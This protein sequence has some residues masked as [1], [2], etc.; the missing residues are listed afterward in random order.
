M[1]SS[2]DEP[3]E[4]ELYFRD[5]LVIHADEEEE[6]EG[7]IVEENS[8]GNF[9]SNLDQQIAE[10]LQNEDATTA[11]ALLR[12]KEKRCKSLKAT[13]QKEQNKEEERKKK[14]LK[15][16]QVKFKQLKRVEEE[17]NHSL[18]SSRASTPT[19]SPKGKTRKSPEVPTATKVPKRSSREGH[20]RS[21][22]RGLTANR[23]SA[24]NSEYKTFLDSLVDLKAGKSEKFTELINRTMEVTSNVQINSVDLNGGFLKNNGQDLN[25]AEVN[26]H[27]RNADTVDSL[28]GQEQLVSLLTELHMA[29]D[30]KVGSRGCI[31]ANVMENNAGGDNSE[32]PDEDD[33]EKKGK[34]LVSGK[35]TKPD[36]SDI[37]LVVKFAHE[38]LDAKHVQDRV[39]NKLPFNLLVAGELEIATIQCEPEKSTQLQIAKT[40]CY[41]KQYLKDEDLRG[42]YDYIRK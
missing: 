20:H 10:A 18:A 23:R 12:E 4:E 7:E 40:I 13:L 8:F 16:M 15:E 32:T 36:E 34:K 38:K 6:E 19:H 29:K 35:C 39:F 37:K 22:S 17:L 2:L 1:D 26:E 24:N 42:G 11:E 3:H 31:S 27:N 28:K 41:H 9:S 21:T 14:K 33:K 5:D 25:F 30:N